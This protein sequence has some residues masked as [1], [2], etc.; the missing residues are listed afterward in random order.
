MIDYLLTGLTAVT[1]AIIA[2]GTGCATFQLL[3]HHAR[4]K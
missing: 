4:H 3:A 1:L 2:F